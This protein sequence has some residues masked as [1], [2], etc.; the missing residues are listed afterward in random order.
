MEMQVEFGRGEAVAPTR[1]AGASS[2]IEAGEERI[3]DFYPQFSLKEDSLPRFSASHSCATC[4]YC[5][6]STDN[7]YRLCFDES[8]DDGFT[9]SDDE[10]SSFTA[11]AEDGFTAQHTLSGPPQ[12]ETQ[13]DNGFTGPVGHDV[14]GFTEHHAEL[15][16]GLTGTTN[17]ISD[18]EV[19]EGISDIID[20]IF[21]KAELN[22]YVL[23]RSLDCSHFNYK[24]NRLCQERDC[25]CQRSEFTTGFASE[26]GRVIVSMKE[27][28]QI[29]NINVEISTMKFFGTSKGIHP[30][31]FYQGV[32]IVQQVLVKRD[33]MFL[34]DIESG[35]DRSDFIREIYKL[36]RIFK[37]NR[38]FG[39]RSASHFFSQDGGYLGNIKSFFSSI[40]ESTFTTLEKLL[41]S[42]YVKISSWLNSIV[43][44]LGD[45]IRAAVNKVLRKL[46]ELVFSVF[47][48]IKALKDWTTNNPKTISV[49]V[50]CLVLFF[51]LVEILGIIT[52]I[53][54]GK[55]F[56]WLNSYLVGDNHSEAFEAQAPAMGPVA[57]VVSL[58][59]AV[60]GLTV[61]DAKIVTEKCRQ[62]HSLVLGATAVA[63]LG[64]AVFMLLPEA[65]RCA[66]RMKYG[67]K[68]D[69]ELEILED[70]LNRSS[71]VIR[72]KSI[73]SVL[74]SEEYFE[75]VQDLMV[76]SS[77]LNKYVS[78]PT[79]GT[80]YVRNLS[81]LMQIVS[82]LEQ[83][84]S[85]KSFRNLPHSIHI[86]AAPGVGKTLV[87]SKLIRDVYSATESEIYT[88]PVAS[89]FWSGFI[90]QKFIICDEFL[91][92]D[93]KKR[94]DIAV[95]YLEL[96]STKCFQP[97]MASVD[98]VA[99]GL[100]GTTAAPAAVIS[101]NNTPYDKVDGVPKEALWRRRNKVIEIRPKPEFWDKTSNK[102]DFK[103][104]T[105]A[106]ISE[107]AWIEARYIPVIP[108]SGDSP[109]PFMSYP[110]LVTSL[111]SDYEAFQATCTLINEGLNGSIGETRDPLSMLNDTLRDLRGIP[112]EEVGLMSL[113]TEFL[114]DSKDKV[115]GLFGSQGPRRRPPQHVRRSQAAARD[116]QGMDEG[117]SSDDSFA[118]ADEVEVQTQ[119]DFLS[120]LDHSNVDVSKIHRH[121]C[122]SCGSQYAHK[123][124]GVFN[125][126]V[127]CKNCPE[128]SS[129]ILHPRVVQSTSGGNVLPGSDGVAPAMESE[130]FST[131]EGDTQTLP[132][133]YD[134]DYSY[135]SDS[136]AVEINNM[137]LHEV[138]NRATTLAYH[139]SLPVVE[140]PAEDYYARFRA[141]YVAP[142]SRVTMQSPME[143]AKEI[144]RSRFRVYAKICGV[145]SIFLGINV[146]INYAS[147]KCNKV[148]SISF[149]A[150][151]ARG[152]RQSTT[153]SRSQR[154]LGRMNC[155]S[156]S[157]VC[158]LSLGD[159][160]INVLP[161][162]GRT[163]LVY[164]HGLADSENV[165]YPSGTDCVL[166][167]NK[168]R[169]NFKL[170]LDLVRKYPEHDVAFVSIPP[171][172]RMNSFPDIINKF[173]SYDEYD[174]YTSSQV[175]LTNG[176]ET[177]YG[178]CVIAENRTYSIGN[179]KQSMDDMLQY[180]ISN[181]SGDC[182]MLVS[183]ISGSLIG[184]YLGIHVA[185]NSSSS[186]PIGLGI[187]L[188]REDIISALE[189]TPVSL[190][191]N[192]SFSAQ[193]PF[194]PELLRGN[195]LEHV[196]SVPLRESVHLSRVSKLKPSVIASELSFE[197]A[198]RMPLLS[199]M[200]PRMDGEDPVLNMINDSLSTPQVIVDDNIVSVIEDSIRSS[201]ESNLSFPIGRRELSFEEAIQGIP[202]VLSSMKTG[203]SCG[204][205][206]LKIR[207][208]KGKKDF[209]WFEDGVCKYS[210]EFRVMV[211]N[212]IDKLDSG[213]LPE[214][215]FVAFL[216]DELISPSK[217][218]QKRSRVIY[219]GD[220]IANVAFRMKFGS[221]L[222]ACNNSYLS[223]PSAIGL[224][225]YSHDM[226]VMYDYL[227][228]VGTNF[229]AGD[230][231]NFD[232]NYNRQVQEMA[233][234]LLME[235]AP[236]TV[237]DSFKSLFISHQ[238]DSPV[239]VSNLVVKFGCS[240]FSGCFFTSIV[241]NIVNEFYFR[242][243][244]IRL[245]PD[246]YFDK[247]IRLKVLGDDH[248]IAVSD[249]AKSRFS[250]LAIQRVLKELGQVYTSDVKEAELTDEFRKFEDISFIGAYPRVVNGL[251]C[252]ALKKASIQEALLWTRDNDDNL[253]AKCTQI[254]ELASIW[255]PE[256]FNPLR[257]EVNEALIKKTGTGVILGGCSEVARVV[258]QRTVASG[259]T[260]ISSFFAQGPL[261]N[262]SLKTSGLTSI[263]PVKSLVSLP[264]NNS[265]NTFMAKKAFNEIPRDLSF[266]TESQ[267]MRTEF[268]WK[269]S[270]ET[271]KTL[272]EV[273]VPF[274]LLGLGVTSNVQNMPFE[275]Y[276]YWEGGVEI[277]LQCNGTPFDAGMLAAYFM[278]LSNHSAELSNIPTT[279]CTF[280]QPNLNSSCTLTIPFVYFRSC[281]NLLNKRESLGTFFAS[282][283]SS[284][285][286]PE[287]SSISISVY[288]RFPNSTFRIPRSI[289]SG[290][291]TKTLLVP[292]GN[293]ELASVNLYEARRFPRR[294]RFSISSQFDEE[295]SLQD[296]FV[297]Q[298]A[299][300]S[301][302]NQHIVY[303]VGDVAGNMPIQGNT[304]SSNSA[305]TTEIDSELEIPMP[306]DNPPLASGAIPTQQSFSGMSKS[307]GVVPTVDL[308]LMPAAMNREHIQI[309]G[310]EQTK[311]AYLLGKR[312]L[313]TTLKW[314][315]S[316]VPGAELLNMEL[317]TRFSLAEGKG[318]PMNIALLNQFMFWRADVVL[319]I[320]PIRTQY[321]SG[322]LQG[323]ISYGNGSLD[324][325]SRHTSF[326]H[327]LES[328]NDVSSHE[329]V[330]NYNAQTEYL[331]TYE[332]EFVVDPVENYSL[333]SF[334]LFVQNALKA[335]DT[336]ASEIEIL[337][338]IHFNNVKIPDEPRA[339]SPFTFNGLGAISGGDRPSTPEVPEGEKY[340]VKVGES[341]IC[342]YL[343]ATQTE[344][345]V[346]LS[347][348]EAKKILTGS[349]SSTVDLVPLDAVSCEGGAILNTS[350]TVFSGG[351]LSRVEVDNQSLNVTFII[352]GVTNTDASVPGSNFDEFSLRLSPFGARLEPEKFFAQ[353]PETTG[354]EV[355]DF[356]SV[357]AEETTMQVSPVRPSKPCLL[358]V[359][360][361]FEYCITDLTEVV[362][363][364]V[365]VFPSIDEDSDA[366]LVESKVEGDTSRTFSNFSVSPTHILSA[367]FAG[368]AGSVKYR[369]FSSSN[370]MLDIVFCPYSNLNQAVPGVP[371]V[372]LI[373]EQTFAYGDQRLA[374][375]SNISGPV[376]RELTY[377]VSGNTW[378]DVSAPFKS[379]FNFHL[380][381][382]LNNT[383]PMSSGTLSI[384]GPK[385]IDD[386]RLF[387]AAGD[388]FRY[389]I[390]RPPVE[391]R[392]DMSGF[393]G[394]IA[395][396]N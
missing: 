69:L 118:S 157:S 237:T 246:L 257:K 126:L 359:G 154:A 225:Q 371:V 105:K 185:G 358:E 32:P 176:M 223:T 224:N 290:R 101:I 183:C 171:S 259:S 166:T 203:T 21:S 340:S 293:N 221:V 279:L 207:T 173:W 152:E 252:G 42:I 40:L 189:P 153:K 394:G 317:N 46:F 130:S 30:R 147:S 164:N 312:C 150:Q 177:R 341:T 355:E 125:H 73:P 12:E 144:L 329:I 17:S 269:S 239:Q 374:S 219:A 179:F 392:F 54:M 24:I 53:S 231:K 161:L 276:T 68:Q 213:L 297:A 294:N 376:A 107:C 381:T 199:S 227:S 201:L 384:G 77:K 39:E 349:F 48:P 162:K 326:S 390:Y 108:N 332:G 333:G 331:R 103:K 114:V 52:V 322:K 100:K 142:Q 112:N 7:L 1:G 137:W 192:D 352:T 92:G 2:A 320:V 265:N 365:S 149:K 253:H 387:T 37:I 328:N 277:M 172:V 284:L 342:Q 262:S 57:L 196:Y 50:M 116:V 109:T 210:E 66:I 110:A 304:S 230:Y 163:F 78:C 295:L 14:V 208:K 56:S 143:V 288:T 325:S 261:P 209:I 82:T 216:K 159:K 113:I 370:K 251:Y 96:V 260:F 348:A 129:E 353:G 307:N 266:G 187:V 236:P 218:S 366:F 145:F 169:V 19:T 298:G 280:L 229:I 160:V 242:Y 197:P 34:L 211:F 324:A 205:P 95:E 309:F 5:T 85:N 389:G 396:F 271:G 248:V 296:E 98:N 3:V 58:A 354:Q 193:A 190:V 380:T 178:N 258:S 362:R 369:I 79:M 195:N 344:V 72:L 28:N 234:K 90:N 15:C 156:P 238:I 35:I 245:V 44:F 281:I 319:T 306:F 217:E 141:G 22:A 123:H 10:N 13:L 388:D 136:I 182:G 64:S 308:Q 25:P 140:T 181:K 263:H 86:A 138:R 122:K 299:S 278:P 232:K 26:D 383:T 188:C 61:G 16:N 303:N 330:I 139:P 80:L 356:M 41:E 379:H 132:L 31:K 256:Y 191:C 8:S 70:W 255:G 360:K 62:V 111:K 368:W 117:T 302:T 241:N 124:A 170:E 38:N 350:T 289:P 222:I 346:R 119:K 75:W 63:T 99:V 318:I 382:K 377:P 215:R 198:K 292:N 240:H 60:F 321:H 274:G 395:G 47:D 9:G 345:S 267:I 204:W 168:N 120:Y 94:L 81:S 228:E 127:Q 351:V 357:P 249:A 45:A 311:L 158:S 327:I 186:N 233:Y 88:R 272:F 29:R 155:Q 367:L 220:L 200:D 128:I 165:E 135:L 310:P 373:N 372:D 148:E 361:K 87:S 151:S 323:V 6:G 313:L 212:F 264:D 273:D 43:G 134:L 91:I 36:R 175:M 202:G 378:I 339:Y 67:S 254:L 336:V 285:N 334:G 93:K 393:T 106:Q 49:A 314:N 316:S 270:D 23:D 283:M 51:V 74:V 386:V 347:Y 115:L 146:L 11:I 286:S 363:R 214:S 20:R 27:F 291:K 65:W 84:R 300:Q 247:E 102:V 375:S 194:G 131:V 104:M 287:A 301:T 243:C 97:D 364:Y 250:P 59:T 76:K 55:L 33:S 391:T 235:L 315:T 4:T 244:F 338:F 335:P 282:P 343:I 268:E 18:E 174:N 305:Q 121:L 226:Q 337:V 184:K 206:L 275:N 167:F 83:Y 89:P 180:N 71:A 385:D 133:V